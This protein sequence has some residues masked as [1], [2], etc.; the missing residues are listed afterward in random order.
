[1]TRRDYVLLSGAM[2]KAKA[3]AERQTGSYTSQAGQHYADGVQSGV[4]RATRALALSLKE[5]NPA[6]DI[7]QFLKDAGVPS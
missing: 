4:E 6:F 7:A 3:D 1:M 5:K 2:L